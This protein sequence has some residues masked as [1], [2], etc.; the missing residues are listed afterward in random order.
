[1]SDLGYLE[2]LLDGAAVEWVPLAEVFH[3][4]TGYTPSKS[5]KEFWENGTIP[6]F[7]MEDIRANGNVLG[8]AMQKISREAVKGSNVFPANSLIFS[9]SATIGEHALV[10]VAHLANQRFTNLT[11]KAEFAK[12]LLPKFLFYHGFVISDWCKG[13]TTKSSFASVDM[14]GFRKL[15]IPIPCP[16]DPQKSLAIQG[17]IVRILDA[18]TALTAELTAELTARKTQYNHYRNQ[19]LSFEG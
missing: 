8:D 11:V 12:I 13:N 18:F 19:L 3:I 2:R 4:R 15:P 9:T 16:D 7:R 10:T 5:Q 17:E 1:M 6:W 14:D